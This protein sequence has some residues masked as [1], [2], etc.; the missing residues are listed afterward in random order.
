MSDSKWQPIEKKIPVPW[1][2]VAAKFYGPSG[3]N[4]IL[5]VHGIL[6]NAG[7]FDRL[8]DLLPRK[9]HYV[10]I[11]LPG[12][13]FSSPFPTGVP[14]QFFDYV[15]TILL[16]L[17]ALKWK[18]C[19][20]LAHSF[21]VQIGVSFSILYPGRLD[22]I[23]AID[24]VMSPPIKDLVSYTQELYNLDSYS[25]DTGRLNTKDEVMYAL[26]FKRGEALNSDAAEA[27]FKRAV[28]KID[29]LYK[30]NRDPRLRNY[31][32]PMFTID[33]HR[34]FMLRFQTPMLIILAE[35]SS[36]HKPL[37]ILAR[38]LGTLVRGN[39]PYHVVSVEGNHDVHNNYPE[40]VAPIIC[41]FLDNDTKSKL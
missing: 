24:G 26:K 34:E 6:D 31:P 41:K 15:Y 28:T 40:R 9:Y 25:K 14:L 12:H 11:D 13:G 33:Q 19:I 1:G 4:N 27:T 29:N 37:A 36:R 21:G 35:S 3:E 22:K 38:E 7:S 39:I 5:V 17:N 16:V 8:I 30:Y 2:H 23:I 32:K 10:S 18:T 20:Y